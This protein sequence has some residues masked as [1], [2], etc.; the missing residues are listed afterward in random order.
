MN[1]GAM[2]SGMMGG[3]GMGMNGMEQGNMMGSQ[4]SYDG[5]GHGG[6]GQQST[7]SRYNRPAGSSV[8]D[9]DYVRGGRFDSYYTPRPVATSLRDAGMKEVPRST[10]GY[11]ASSS[12]RRMKEIERVVYD[13]DMF[14]YPSVPTNISPQQFR[15]SSN[16]YSRGFSSDR[17]YS[18]DYRSSPNI[19]GYSNDLR[20]LEMNRVS[21]SRSEYYNDLNARR[22]ASNRSRRDYD[23][24][25]ADQGARDG[26]MRE[27]R[28]DDYGRD[29]G[30]S[31]YDD[32]YR[33]DNRYEPRA[34]RARYD[35]REPSDF[36]YED[37]RRGRREDYRGDERYYSRSNGKDYYD[38]DLDRRRAT[39][40]RREDDRYDRRMRR[41]DFQR[42]NDRRELESYGAMGF[43]DEFIDPYYDRRPPP[44]RGP[45]RDGYR[46][47]PPRT[48]NRQSREIGDITGPNRLTRQGHVGET[49]GNDFNVKRRQ[50]WYDEPTF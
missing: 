43:D 32:D 22:P 4:E 20:D 26:G 39:R 50:N 37:D 7:G 30:R 5:I 49:V 21:S 41:D 42:R 8:S 33:D 15:S 11:I 9:A 12:Q 24:N 48:M 47:A 46:D 2:G 25:Y 6:Y 10:L 19:A 40:R 29:Y 34:G 18:G 17:E 38:R 16:D 14:M 3:A 35:S 36:D 13:D 27:S 28:R 31:R 44:P 23:R 45:P 1:N